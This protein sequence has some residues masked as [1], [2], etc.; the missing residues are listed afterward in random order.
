MERGASLLDSK[1]RLYEYK[2][3][4]RPASSYKSIIDFMPPKI[5]RLLD[6]GCGPGTLT[7]PLSSRAE[8]AV[9]ID[10]SPSALALARQR[11]SEQGNPNIA[12]VIASA[13]AL[14]FAANA[15]DAVVSVYAVRFTNIAKTFSEMGRVLTFGGHLGVRDYLFTSKAFAFWLTY[16]P[17]MLRSLP[18][19][20]RHYGV[21][22]SLEMLVYL[23]TP[24]GIAERRKSTSLTANEFERLAANAFPSSQIDTSRAGLVLWEKPVS[25]NML[26]E[27]TNS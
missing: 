6:V 16:I 13:E 15:F 14:P 8:F 1:A 18:K 11:Q 2:A 25:T 7:F 4:T 22:R 23:S 27:A 20:A 19:W 26:S 10:V 17:Y 3:R 24:S 21:R 9:G 5:V 12:W